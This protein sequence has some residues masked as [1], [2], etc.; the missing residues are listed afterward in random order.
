MSPP[1]HPQRG[2]LY[3][4]TAYFLWGFF[5]LYWHLLAAATALEIL[6]H[7]IVWSLGFV[8]LLLALGRRLGALREVLAS[9]R[10]LALLAFA[11]TV[12][13]TNWG[14]YIYAVNAGHVVE[15]SLGYFI[16][17]LVTVTLGVLAL[18]ERLSRVQWAAIAVG[19][20]AVAA[21]ALDYGRVPAIALVL[22]IS[23]ALYGLA[24]KKAG[25]GAVESLLVE[26]AVLAIPAGAYLA[27]IGAAGQSTFARA[28][29][30]HTVLLVGSGVATAVP[31]LAFG[32]AANRIPLSALGLL[33]YLSP[34]LQFLVGVLV[35]R[36]PMPASRIAGFVLVWIALAVLAV[37]GFRMRHAQIDVTRVASPE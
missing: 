25:V 15:A 10:R 27:W 3:G 33:Q 1:S 35:F 5:P 14:V 22:A 21:L 9:G 23:F 12:L 6:A 29:A 31:L 36:E 26:T 37:E 32:A 17:P 28:G 20:A 13:A 2:Y 8:A 4:A 16:N 34:A 11:G 24:K 30:L 18:R 7:R 19:A